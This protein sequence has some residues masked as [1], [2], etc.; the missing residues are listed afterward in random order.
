[1]ASKKMNSKTLSITEKNELL[2]ILKTRFEKNMKRHKG[3]EW[4][5][6]QKKLEKQ[7]EK[8]WSLNEMEQSGGEP[9]VTG[10]DKATDQY[11]FTDCSAESPKGRRSLCYDREGL[12]T[13]KE[14]KPANSAMDLAMEMGVEMLS[15]EEYRELQKTGPYDA[16]TSS[17]LKTPEP[18]RNLGGALFGDYRFKT[19]F[20]YHNTAPSYYAS[21]GFRSRLL[22]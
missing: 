9:D 20:I 12:D 16:K 15:P 8:L 1:M 21:R 11:C 10:Y 14:F 2:Q 6:I 19:I 13:R 18:I 5:P 4:E 7:Q 17:W 22:V 3:L